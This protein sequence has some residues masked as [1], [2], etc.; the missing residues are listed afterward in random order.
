MRLVT[1]TNWAYGATVI[2]TLASGT[3]MLFASNAQEQERSAVEQRYQLDQTS[4]EIAADVTALSDQARDYVITGDP[5]QLDLYRHAVGTLSSIEDRLHRVKD[6]GASADEISAIAE[7]MRLADGLEDEQRAA[8]AARDKGDADQAR[9][10]LFGPEYDRE[11]DRIAGD[12]EQFQYRLDQR[13]DGEVVAASAIARLWKACSEIVLGITGILFLSVLYFIFKRRVL[14]PVV[15]LSDVVSRLAAQDYA[16][17]APAYDQIDEIGDMAQAIR[18]FRENGIERQRLEEERSIDATIRSQLSRMTQRMQ[19]CET[20]HHLK[21]VIESFVP[22]IAPGRAGKLYLFDKDRNTLVETNSWLEPRHSKM[23]FVPSSCWALQRG[24]MHRPHGHAVDVPCDHLNCEEQ[25]FDPICL[26][27]IAHRA[28]LGVLYLEPRSEHAAS[29]PEI[30]EIYLKMLA[31]NISLAV[32]NL[33]LR[34]ALREMAMVDPLTGLSNRRHLEEV[35]LQQLAMA[36][37]PDHSISCLM[38]DVDHFKKFNDKFGHDA[39]DAV[40]C[41]VGD[42]LH[43]L[44][45]SSDFAFRYGGEE[46]LLLMPGLDGEQAALRA[47]EIRL[48]IRSLQVTHG[49]QELGRITASIGI[50]T[51]PDHCRF[52]ELVQTADAALLRAKEAGRDRVVGAEARQSGQ[53]IELAIGTET[54]RRLNLDEPPMALPRY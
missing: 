44:T 33:R 53:R 52:S 47:E 6:I 31:E 7:A 13:T 40:L 50:S 23:E 48:K 15:R 38:L 12:I 45:R 54:D 3:T 25:S 9:R 39:G 51:A 46:F 30:S 42:L 35:L 18:V 10:I 32:G 16:V 37:R 8:V 20:M 27:L 29:S 4:S 22:A 41:V 14:R 28:T 43:N 49:G 19:E 17:E 24:E 5:L 34:E 36:D 2:L 21:R 1:I 26:P 11:L